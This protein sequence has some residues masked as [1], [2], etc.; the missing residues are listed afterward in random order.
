MLRCHTLIHASVPRLHSSNSSSLP[1]TMVFRMQ[2]VPAVFEWS[3]VLATPRAPLYLAGPEPPSVQ[4]SLFLDEEAQA[5]S[6]V[7]QVLLNLRG[8]A[9]DET[10]GEFLYGVTTPQNIALLCHDPAHHLPDGVSTVLGFSRTTCLRLVLRDPFLID[11]PTGVALPLRA[12]RRSQQLLSSLESFA[13]QTVFAVHVEEDKISSTAALQRL[14]HVFTKGSFL[15]ALDRYVGV[16]LN[17]FLDDQAF[18][19]GNADERV[20]D[21]GPEEE[22]R[23]LML[24]PNVTDENA[25]PSQKRKSPHDTDA[26]KEESA[27]YYIP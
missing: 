7:V 6:L 18:G 10:N 8:E 23:T 24:Y 21:G 9:T 1:T 15:C 5:A 2:N 27:D 3:D 26:V 20:R 4:L 13:K 11:Y 16:R 14:C 19:S 17:R 22:E 25:P 12:N